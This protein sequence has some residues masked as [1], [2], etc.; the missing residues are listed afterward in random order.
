[1]HRPAHQKSPKLGKEGLALR[2][3]SELEP[4]GAAMQTACARGLLGFQISMSFPQNIHHCI[5]ATAT[6]QLVDS[7]QA[8]WQGAEVVSGLV[9]HRATPIFPASS[10]LAEGIGWLG[11]AS[12]L[13]GFTFS[14]LHV[15]R[16]IMLFCSKCYEA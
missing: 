3:V 15:L 1:M 9:S 6:A 8:S 10:T 13:R 11:A 12:S 2:L 14:S 16:Y 7:T 5:V 4:C